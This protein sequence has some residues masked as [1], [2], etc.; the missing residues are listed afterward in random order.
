[1]IVA[2]LVA[3]A[4]AGG[5]VLAALR[6]ASRVLDEAETLERDLDP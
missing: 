5:L 1:M 2:A 6:Y 4:L 3:A